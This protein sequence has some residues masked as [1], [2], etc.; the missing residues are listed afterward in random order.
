GDKVAALLQE[1]QRRQL[2]LF[3]YQYSPLVEVHRWSG[4]PAG[5]ELF[6]NVVIFENYP[7]EVPGDG[8]LAH[9]LVVDA[10]RSTERP[11][12][13]LCLQ[14]GLDRRLTVRVT[15]SKGSYER[16]AIERMMGH[17]SRLL[18]A[19]VENPEGR[20][21]QLEMLAEAERQQL[22]LQ[23]NRT[24][25]EYPRERCIH[26][27]FAQQAR[28]TPQAVAVTCEGEQ[29]SYA[30]LDECAERLA[31][32][33]VSLG[34]GPE[35]IVGLCVERGVQ[36]VVGLLGI[37]KAGGAYLPLD[38]SYPRERLQFML[39]DAGAAV[40]L[41]H[42]QLQ[43]RIPQHG[44]VQYL[45][46]LPTDPGSESGVRVR[47]RLHPDNLAYVIYTSGSTG[48]PKAVGIA[49][50]NVVRLFTATQ[51]RFHFGTQDVWTLFHSYA[52]D[53]SVWEIFGAL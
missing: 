11:H 44:C 20:L 23:W 9:E 2:E 8:R 5:R 37:L 14:F 52:F 10:V 31:R 45:D 3:E 27:L 34:V 43:E 33:L 26:E 16:G 50:A 24:E 35:V 25:K 42:S 29:L 12:Y 51:E 46:R 36:M 40:L 53:F 22:L 47:A 15:Y 21:S 19:I 13:P 6:D 30:Q 48:K 32:R 49:H 28:R 41:T 17:F 39:Q 7:R 38:P 4:L 18:G 1:L